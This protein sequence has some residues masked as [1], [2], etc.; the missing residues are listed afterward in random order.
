MKN[1]NPIEALNVE[2]LT[3]TEI[4]NVAEQ[5]AAGVEAGVEE[6]LDLIIKI[7]FLKKALE[8][9]KKKILDD[10]L[11]ELD[12]HPKEGTKI[13][14]VQIQQVESGVKYDYSNCEAW[15]ERDQLVKDSTEFKKELESKLKGLKKPESIL[16]EETGEV[17][18]L[19]PPAR[20]STTT[21]KITFKK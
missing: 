21:V 9:A 13:A 18:R 12:L 2:A 14:G 7:D 10:C 16:D 3:K 4:S 6:P 1:S 8:E 15:K 19:V 5:I 20:T 17:T 11:Q